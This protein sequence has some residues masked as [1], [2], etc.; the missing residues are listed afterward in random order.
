MLVA[1]SVWGVW[2]GPASMDLWALPSGDAY[3]PVICLS[4]MALWGILWNLSGGSHVLTVCVSCTT[5]EL[6]SSRPFQVLQRGSSTSVLQRG[7]KPHLGSPGLQQGWPRS[8][9]LEWGEQSLDIVLSP[10]LWHSGLGSWETCEMPSGSVL[11]YRADY[12]W[13]PIEP[14]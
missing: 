9:A 7:S 4:S 11:H 10:R 14:Y 5:K 2:N 12:T 1:L 6:P 13:L 8:D 3:V